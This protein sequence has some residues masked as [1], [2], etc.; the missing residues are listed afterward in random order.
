M[1]GGR[2]RKIVAAIC[3][4]RYALKRGMERLYDISFLERHWQGKMRRRLPVG[5]EK[6]VAGERKNHRPLNYLRRK[7]YDYIDI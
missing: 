5:K 1:E 2:K 6:R 7:R 4:K 3:Q